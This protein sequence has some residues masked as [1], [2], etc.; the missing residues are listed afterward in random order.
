MAQQ[1]EEISEHALSADEREAYLAAYRSERRAQA[2]SKLDS[3]LQ[4][5]ADLRFSTENVLDRR[6]E[7]RRLKEQVAEARTEL[8]QARTAGIAFPRAVPVSFGD[9]EELL[10][11]EG[12]ALRQAEGAQAE[13]LVGGSLESLGNYMHLSVYV[14]HRELEERIMETATTALPEELST[15]LEPVVRAV[16]TAVLGRP[17]ASLTV[18]AEPERGVIYVDDTLAG[19]GRAELPFL[20]PGRREIRVELSAGESTERTVTLEPEERREVAVRVAVSEAERIRLESEPAG[21]DVYDGALW[22]GVTPLTLERPSQDR[23]FLLELEEYDSARIVVGPDTPRQRT[24]TLM[25]DV[26]DEVAFVRERRDRFYRALGYFALSVP[27]P[28][29]MYGAFENRDTL[30]SGGA[31]AP[32]LSVSEAQQLDR[33]RRLFAL[34]A[35]G[36]S[37]VSASLLTNMIV[38][39]VQYV[40]ASEH[41]HIQPA[42]GQ[43]EP[44]QPAGQAEPG[45]GEPVQDE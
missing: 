45:Q 38:K 34:G 15:R 23:A 9:T 36:T 32:G 16:A 14:Y 25:P 43:A 28:I 33:E 29:V 17:W 12:S 13:L 8:E 4:Q 35:W 37:A 21:A 42:A 20:E 18:E 5:L 30:F 39:L 26:R 19:V 6:E 10:S 1:L 7:R 24:V 44:E 31:A 3:R 41:A 27:V 22:R 40:R 11:A 2:G